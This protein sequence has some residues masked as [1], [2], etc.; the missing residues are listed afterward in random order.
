MVKGSGVT[1]QSLS[2]HKAV[3]IEL[4]LKPPTIPLFTTKIYDYNNKEWERLNEDLRL[5]DWS[6]VLGMGNA[7][8]M[9]ETWTIKYK[10]I[11]LKYIPIR[12]VKITPNDAPWITV[13]SKKSLKHRNQLYK[14]DRNANTDNAWR[15][16]RDKRNLVIEEIC[17]AKR[18]YTLNRIKP[19]VTRDDKLWWKLVK[20]V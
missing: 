8:E 17:E 12:T 14:V 5:T 16:Y 6:H 13:Q 10:E 19:A 2:R 4:K 15:R 7:D 18:K 3:F 9:A 11:Q 1:P 20:N